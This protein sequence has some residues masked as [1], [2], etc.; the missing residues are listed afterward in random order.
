MF[1]IHASTLCNHVVSLPTVVKC[2]IGDQM[3]LRILFLVTFSY[4]TCEEGM[5]L[6]Q[7]LIKAVEDGTGGGV[8]VA[9]SARLQDSED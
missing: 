4:V 5:R 9:V 1:A 8:Q 6:G 3:F 2:C 7:S